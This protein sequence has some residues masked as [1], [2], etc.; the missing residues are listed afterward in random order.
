MI[1]DRIDFD[2]AFYLE[3]STKGEQCSLHFSFKTIEKAEIF[4]AEMKNQGMPVEITHCRVT[5]LPAKNENTRGV[6]IKDD[7]VQIN[8]PSNSKPCEARKLFSLLF[9]KRANHNFDKYLVGKY[10]PYDGA[11]QTL[12]SNGKIKIYSLLKPR[13]SLDERISQTYHYYQQLIFASFSLKQLFL[14][15]DPHP[16]VELISSIIQRMYIL[17]SE[18]DLDIRTLEINKMFPLH[19]EH[20]VK[21]WKTNC[22]VEFNQKLKCLYFIFPNNIEAARLFACMTSSTTFIQKKLD[23]NEII[24]RC[25]NIVIDNLPLEDSSPHVEFDMENLSLENASLQMGFDCWNQYAGLPFNEHIHFYSRTKNNTSRPIM[26]SLSDAMPGT[27]LM[28]FCCNDLRQRT[29]EDAAIFPI[30]HPICKYIAEIISRVSHGWES[31]LISS[32]NNCCNLFY[33]NSAAINDNKKMMQIK[34]ACLENLKAN[35]SE[36][37]RARQPLPDII[38]AWYASTLPETGEK[39]VKEIIYTGRDNTLRD[40]TGTSKLINALLIQFGKACEDILT[41][42]VNQDEVMD[43]YYKGFKYVMD[44][45]YKGFKY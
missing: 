41:K 7:Y 38:T 5:I 31:S 25:N 33:D 45:Y 12:D 9:Q 44:Q 42:P 26:P 28:L 21:N 39:T 18:K 17:T 23:H 22:F 27:S 10:S 19:Y 4:F 24:I 29:L 3:Y 37:L 14:S 16:P 30:I 13:F 1:S 32:T 40:E 11:A 36:G 15:V 35:I 6:F 8:F 2:D 34:I 43:Q 20:I